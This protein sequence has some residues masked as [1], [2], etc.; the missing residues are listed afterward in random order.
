MGDGPRA[1]VDC[2]GCHTA[3]PAKPFAG[4][5]RIATP[6]GAIFAPNLTPDRQSGIGDWSDDDFY[7]ALHDGVAPD[8]SRYYPAFP[9]PSFT[10]LTRDDVLAIRAW[11]ATL[12]PVSNRPPPAQLR[13]PLN[14]RLVM[15]GWNWLFFTP[16]TFKPDPENSDAWNRGAYLVE[17][18]AHCGACHT[19]KNAFGADRRDRL[20]GGGLIDGWFAPRLD[21]APR[22]GLKSWSMDDIAEYLGSGRNASA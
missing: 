4:G 15:R 20:Y 12:A 17:G 6:F 1:A 11:L 14:Y 3:D 9:Y 13:W 21:N 10:K 7:R 5:R 16:G 19:P 2:A 18:A 8:G 22:S